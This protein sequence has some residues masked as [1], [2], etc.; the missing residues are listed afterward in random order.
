MTNKELLK[1]IPFFSSLSDEVLSKIEGISRKVDYNKGEY[2]FHEG[3]LT[4]DLYLV[5]SGEI[6]IIKKNN[7]GEI[8]IATVKDNEFFGE[9]ALFTDSPRS[10]GAYTSKDSTL[11]RIKSDNLIDL[12]YEVPEVAIEIIRIQGD[13]LRK[14]AKQ[15]ESLT[16]KLFELAKKIT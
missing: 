16:I 7:G 3:S 14:S 15:I 4:S 1:K 11:I 6:K 12:I 8:A 10:A 2:V 9:V 5:A 13:R